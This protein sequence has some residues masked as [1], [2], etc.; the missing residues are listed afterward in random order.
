MSPD[1]PE[2][3]IGRLEQ[4]VARLEQ[5]VD[6]LSTDVRTLAPL[7]IAH[8]EMRV[9]LD[10]MQ[11]QLTAAVVEAQTARKE[12][13]QLRT[14]L[15]ERA[16]VQ[17]KERRADRWALVMALIASGGLIVAALQVLGVPT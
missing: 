4:H 15:E 2:S 6:D 12:L 5:R 11:V 10:N 8:A 9:V 14:H 17:R 1:S 13:G 16:E 7:V 3:R